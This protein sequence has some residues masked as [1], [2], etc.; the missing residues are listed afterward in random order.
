MKNRADLVQRLVDDLQMPKDREIARWSPKERADY[1]RARE[2]FITGGAKAVRG[3][4]AGGETSLQFGVELGRDA[5]SFAAALSARVS[6]WLRARRIE[7]FFFMRKAP[8]MR[9]R[10]FGPR[11]LAFEQALVAFLDREVARGTIRSHRRGVYDAETYQ[12]G[13]EEGLRLMHAHAT[14]DSVWALELAKTARSEET[15]SI[16]SL[17]A[18]NHLLRQCVG[19]VFE[20][21]DVWENMRLAG[22]V[23]DEHINR[24]SLQALE[25]SSRAQRDLILATWHT[26]ELILRSVSRADRLLMQAYFR[27]NVRWSKKL[28]A[29]VDDNA[30]LYGVRKILPFYVIF[31]WNRLGFSPDLQRSL[32]FYMRFNLNPKRS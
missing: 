18:L 13:G 11:V 29:A 9:L 25:E 27:S 4:M 12:F 14:Y 8:G 19:D 28:R 10:F 7:Y 21:W 2:A 17:L 30:L 16:L 3:A 24:R 1:A 26:P 32:T 5:R 23:V 6:S 15:V 20:G 22:R 31:H